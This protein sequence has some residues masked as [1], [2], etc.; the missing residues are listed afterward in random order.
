MLM[1]SS[2]DFGFRR[3]TG[4]FEAYGPSGMRRNPP[5]SP[6]LDRAVQRALRSS[7][8]YA[9]CPCTI[10]F[11]NRITSSRAYMRYALMG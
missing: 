8:T 3:V 6:A 1:G 9:A 10:F 11:L 5:E 7:A 4:T 2:A